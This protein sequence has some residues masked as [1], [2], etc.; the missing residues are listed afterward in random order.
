S[1]E[2]EAKETVNAAVEEAKA[3]P[4]PP[5]DD[6]WY[7]IYSRGQAAPVRRGRERNEV[8]RHYPCRNRGS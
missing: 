6:L 5:N 2:K 7:D 3:A 4:E 8:R 1:I